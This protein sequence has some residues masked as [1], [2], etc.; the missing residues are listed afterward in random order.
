MSRDL[1]DVRLCVSNAIALI[2]HA[3]C[4]VARLSVAERFAQTACV[5]L[6]CSHAFCGSDQSTAGVKSQKFRAAKS[7]QVTSV[8]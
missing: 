6:P 4:S 3:S 1:S 2:N 5:T 8:P 7:L